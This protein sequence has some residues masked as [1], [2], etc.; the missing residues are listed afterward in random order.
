MARKTVKKESHFQRAKR[1]YNAK[2]RR[3]IALT[4]LISVAVEALDAEET[5]AI[6]E[7]LSLVKDDVDAAREKVEEYGADP[8]Y[9][10][11]QTVM[12]YQSAD[13]ASHVSF[14]TEADA[15]G[16]FHWRA[17]VRKGKTTNIG[18]FLTFMVSATPVDKKGSFKRKKSAETAARNEAEKIKAKF[19][20]GLARMQAKAKAK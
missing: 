14:T 20:P 7:L 8:N 2:N 16:L 6:E 12:N 15:N 17:L 5:A 19:Y 4:K 13:L 11:W 1:F 10:N 18:G 9:L 3:L